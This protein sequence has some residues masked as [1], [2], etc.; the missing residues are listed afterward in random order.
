MAPLNWVMRTITRRLLLMELRV[1]LLLLVPRSVISF[2]ISM[3]ICLIWVYGKPWR[4]LSTKRR[5]PKAWPMAMNLWRIRLFLMARLTQ[6]FAVQRIT[7]ITWIVLISFL[8]RQDGS[9]ISPLASG[10]RM[11][12]RFMWSL[13]ALL[14]TVPSVPLPRCSRASLQKLALK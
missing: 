10:K 6:I 7:P 2:W 9:W 13:P 4:M 1:N 8:M 11:E 12:H 5:F 14:T 3:G